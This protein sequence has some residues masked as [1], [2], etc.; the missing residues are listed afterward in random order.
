MRVACPA[1]QFDLDPGAWGGSDDMVQL[2]IAFSL[3]SL[4]PSHLIVS[5]LTP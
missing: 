3:K 2:C 4:L 5:A 1:G